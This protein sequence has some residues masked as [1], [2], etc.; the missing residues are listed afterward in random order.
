MCKGDLAGGGLERV[1][2]AGCTRHVRCIPGSIE[3]RRLDGGREN[4]GPGSSLSSL[5]L[6]KGDREKIVL[7]SCDKTDMGVTMSSRWTRRTKD[8]V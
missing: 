7:A 1:G 6:G 4:L 3:F 2:L 8:S 5:D